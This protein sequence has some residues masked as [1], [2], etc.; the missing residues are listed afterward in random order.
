[1][2]L[3]KNTLTKVYCINYYPT[4]I[5]LGEIKTFFKFEAEMNTFRALSD[6]KK[7]SPDIHAFYMSYNYKKYMPH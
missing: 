3:E 2:N 6:V 4:H 5:E 1:M 7:L